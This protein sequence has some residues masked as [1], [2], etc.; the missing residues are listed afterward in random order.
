MYLDNNVTTNIQWSK[1]SKY[2]QHIYIQ[3][4][5]DTIKH[6]FNE[7]APKLDLHQECPSNDSNCDYHNPKEWKCLKWTLIEI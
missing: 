1:R 7:D 6:L 5:L 2:G 4:D 3:Q